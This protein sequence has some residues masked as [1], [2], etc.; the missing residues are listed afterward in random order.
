M[1]RSDESRLTPSG[2]L[3]LAMIAASIALSAVVP[4]GRTEAASGGD[5]DLVVS[6][7]VVEVGQDFWVSGTFNNAEIH[8]VRGIN[9]APPEDSQPVAF[10]APDEAS[11]RFRFSAELSEVGD[12]TIWA[13]VVDTECSDS[14]LVKIVRD[15]PDTAIRQP[16]NGLV[17]AIGSILIVL[18]LVLLWDRRRGASG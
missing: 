5:C 17:Q 10:A 2:S 7:S 18:A 16:A 13:I 6:P 3:L 4:T 8:Q 12:W 11:F 15:L 14:A 1:D 9:V